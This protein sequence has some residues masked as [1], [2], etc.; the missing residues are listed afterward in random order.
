MSKLM[1]LCFLLI[2]CH[3]TVSKLIGNTKEDDVRVSKRSF[4][5][6]PGSFICN[7]TKICIAQ[8][9]ICDDFKDCE[10]G[11]DEWNCTDEN[12]DKYFNSLFV[13]RPDEDRDKN[14]LKECK[15]SYPVPFCQCSWKSL[16]CENRGLHSIPENLP[17]DIKELDLSGNFLPLIKHSNF[18]RLSFLQTL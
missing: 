15:L 17:T 18:T 1:K 7:S 6:K 13:K 16:F 14:E 10:D 3:V 4:E 9:F 5:C 2:F 8:M 12:K 11:S